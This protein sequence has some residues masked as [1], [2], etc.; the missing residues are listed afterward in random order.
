VLLVIALA[1]LTIAPRAEAST[2]PTGFSETTEATG[3]TSPVAVDWAPDGRKFVAEKSGRVRVVNP[4]SSAA[5][6]LLD[7][8]DKVNSYSDR[9]LLGLAVDT[10]F[11]N[12]GYLY[13]L[14]VHELRPGTPD[15]SAAMVQRLT[16]VTVK[17]DNTL[18][19]PASPETVIL[20]SDVS[21]SCP[22]PDNT[23]DCLPADFYWHQVGTVRSDPTDGTLWVGLGDSHAHAIDSN[24]YRP[25]DTSSPLG[26]ILHIDRQGRGLANHPFCPADANLDHVCTKVYARGFRNP[27]R[28]TLRPGKG[29]VVGDVGA[30]T[31]EEIDLIEP[32][33]N[34]GWPCY[35]GSIRTPLYRE[36]ARCLEEYAR[37]G[38]VDGATPPDWSYPHGDGASVV[39]GPVYTGQAYPDDYRGDIFVGDYVQ[40]WVKRLEVNAQDDVTQV[41]DFASEWPPGVDLEQTPGGKIAYVDIGYGSTPSA[42]RRFDFATTGSPPT[43]NASAS[44]TS[45]DAPLTVEFTGSGSSDPDGS[46]LTYDWDF[47]DGSPHS[48]ETN[49][50]H[51][52]SNPGAYEARLTVSDGEGGSDSKTVLITVEGNQAPTAAIDAPADESS[53]RNGEP[54][55]LSGSA[56]DPEDGSI[57]DPGLSWQVLLHHGTHVHEVGNF[58]GSQASFTPFVD[59]DADSFYEIRLTATDS[60]GRTDTRTIELRPETSELTL[61]SD[62]VGANVSYADEPAAPA[63]VTKRAAVGFRTTVIAAPSYSAGGVTY[64]FDRWSD[65]GARQH[66]ITVPAEDTT[67]TAHYVPTDTTETLTFVPEADTYVDSSVPTTSKGSSLGLEVDTTPTKQSFLRFPVSGIGGRDVVGVRLRMYNVNASASGGRV[68]SMSSDSW[69]ESTT[70]STRPA[71]DGSQ[72]GSFGGVAVNNWYSVDLGANAVSGDGKLSLAMDSTNADGARWASR[73]TSTAPQLIVEVASTNGSNASPS[74]QASASPTSGQAPLAVQFTSAGSSDP[75]GAALAYDWDFGDGTARSSEPA[76]S[77]TY[78]APGTYEARLTVTDPDGATDSASVTVNVTNPPPRTETLTFTPEADTYVVSSHPTASKGTSSGLEVESSPVKQSFLRFPVSGIGGRDVVGVRLRMYNVNAS[79]SGG[80]IFSMSSNSWSQ[81]T[82]YSTR[83]AID[84]PLRGSYGRVAAGNWYATDLGANAVTGDGKVSLAMDSTNT[85][86]A[87]WASRET[88]NDPQLIVEVANP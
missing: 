25:Y 42:I 56:T 46:T 53:Y 61:A 30:S 11:V 62:P 75:E 37:E 21:G 58:S 59:H 70:Y 44:P 49:P 15:S 29:P 34:Y 48:S 39:A 77:H 1:C 73:H 10:N 50:V 60:G 45:G 9:G 69:S 38:T 27:F 35:E 81:S 80:R 40:G 33:K 55:A 41:H 85:D 67:L 6:T 47:G 83:P 52:Y 22:Q 68:F 65:G 7:I 57:G 2:L 82:T 88:A 13:L 3:F 71:I 23:R 36:Q 19:N 63:P 51:T 12:N 5:M 72:L 17:P 74:A 8:R 76:P 16:R 86:M 87:R 26:K 31:Q 14:Y 54:V 64:G 24:S 20:G 28:F 43:A 84:G 32:G 79:A 78:S 66:E 18:E 4:G